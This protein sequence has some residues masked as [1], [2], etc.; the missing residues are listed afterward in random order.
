M[1]WRFI[2]AQGLWCEDLYMLKVYGV[3]ILIQVHR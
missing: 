1:V 3:K 2:Y